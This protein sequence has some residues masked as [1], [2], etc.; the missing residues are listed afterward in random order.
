MSSASPC[1]QEKVTISRS[2]LLRPLNPNS[3]SVRKSD[4][5]GRG[6]R[7]GQGH[8]QRRKFGQ[9]G[10]GVMLPKRLDDIILKEAV[11][12]RLCLAGQ[13]IEQGFLKFVKKVG[14][15]PLFAEIKLDRFGSRGGNGTKVLSRWVRSLGLTDPRLSPSHSWRHRLRTLGRRYGLAPDILDAIMGHQRKTVA[16]T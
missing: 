15:G 11:P 12:G 5:Y 1:R 4:C 14:S 16:D 9:A 6:R 3:R 8:A 13:L 7:D 2:I 10:L